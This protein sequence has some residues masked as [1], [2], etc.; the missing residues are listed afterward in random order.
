MLHP[1]AQDAFYRIV[2]DWTKEEVVAFAA[3]FFGRLREMDDLASRTHRRAASQDDIDRLDLPLVA[4]GAVLRRPSVA[5]MEWLRT[6]AAKWWGKSP[7]AYTLALAYACAHRDRSAFDR[8]R[9]RPRASLRVWAWAVRQRAGE[10]AL[11]RAAYALL[12]PPDDSL[13]WF[14]PP[15][16][17]GDRTP[18]DLAEVALE[19]AKACGGTPE[20]WLWEVAEDDFWNAWLSILDD[21]EHADAKARDNPESWWRR[22]RKALA[23]CASALEADAAAWHARRHPAAETAG[24]Q[25]SAKPDVTC[26]PLATPSGASAGADERLMPGP[27]GNGANQGKPGRDGIIEI[28][29]GDG[30]N[31]EE[32]RNREGKDGQDDPH[33]PH[34]T[35]MPPVAQGKE[36][37]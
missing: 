35:A 1:L 21:A 14:A 29:R 25:G 33:A 32:S 11:R 18:P 13:A 17:D 6:C 2:R 3:A 37:K 23:A 26:Q 34:H 19:I 30:E 27:E 5:A 9:S 8:L 28:A 24:C 20:H 7:R 31:A 16:D 22:H 15:D 4:G 10:E 36:E 12:P